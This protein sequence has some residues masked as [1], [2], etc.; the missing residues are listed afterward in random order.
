MEET[1][2]GTPLEERNSLP[3]SQAM[4]SLLTVLDVLD[5]DVLIVDQES[6]VRF[7]NLAYLD[8]YQSALARVGIPREKILGL[9]I[10]Q[11]PGGVK[12][13]ELFQRVMKSGKPLQKTY[14]HYD[15]SR[16]SGLSDLVPI[17]TDV[18]SGLMV[19]M[20]EREKLQALSREISHYKDL[21][22]SLQKKLDAKDNLPPRFREITGVSEPFVKALRVGAQVAPTNSSVCILG[23]S[24]TGKEVFA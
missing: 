13:W 3:H 18:F 1:R 21:A 23:E 14:F 11:L 24:G 9:P 4:D 15:E 2:N 22:A 19:L 8:S 16:Y 12:E 20:Q 5:A 7:Y 10:A 17:V 6:C